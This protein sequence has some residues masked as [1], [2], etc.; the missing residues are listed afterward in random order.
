MMVGAFPTFRFLHTFADEI[1]EAPPHP[2]S[3]SSWRAASTSGRRSGRPRGLV[4][5]GVVG[6]CW[7]TAPPGGPGFEAWGGGRRS[8]APAALLSPAARR[9]GSGCRRALDSPC[10]SPP[11]NPRLLLPGPERF[12]RRRL[13]LPWWIGGGLSRPRS[14]SASR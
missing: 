13:S 1:P 8:R 5:K 3:V 14:R 11:P 2:T 9:R 7:L 12:G 6:S 10:V 4:L